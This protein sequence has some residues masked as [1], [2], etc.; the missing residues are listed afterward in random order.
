MSFEVGDSVV[1]IDAS[2][3]PDVLT[4][5]AVYTVIR[6]VDFTSGRQGVALREV[7]DWFAFRASRFRPTDKVTA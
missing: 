2:E 4:E 5:G 7:G 1:C 6:D 3:F